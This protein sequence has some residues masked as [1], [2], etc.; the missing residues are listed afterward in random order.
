MRALLGCCLLPVCS[1]V[2]FFV[3]AWKEGKKAV[4]GVSSFKHTNPFT[5]GANL[6]ASFNLNYILRVPIS[7]QPQ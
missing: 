6:V 5:S 2:L 4:I 7:K 3:C 1:H